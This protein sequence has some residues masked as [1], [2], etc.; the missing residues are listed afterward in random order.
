MKFQDPRGESISKLS[1][2]LTDSLDDSELEQHL[3]YGGILHPM[4]ARLRLEIM[5]VKTKTANH[6]RKSIRRHQRRRGVSG[7]VW[8]T[9]EYC[10]Y[11]VQIPT[12]DHQLSATKQDVKIVRGQKGKII[13]F[14]SQV[15]K[16]FKLWEYEEKRPTEEYPWVQ[17]PW[18]EALSKLQ[19]AEWIE[20]DFQDYIATIHT[21]KE[22]KKGI[23]ICS[24]ETF[25]QPST[26]FTIFGCLQPLTS[27]DNS[28]IWFELNND[29]PSC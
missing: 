16:Y 11:S 3:C 24:G 23:Y 29:R 14:L 28:P 6:Y 19:N 26:H 9:I 25:E 4:E 2:H 7:L 8:E 5:R 22:V 15:Q 27:S 18:E 20:V 13:E 1:R 21:A 10:G 17:T 12:I